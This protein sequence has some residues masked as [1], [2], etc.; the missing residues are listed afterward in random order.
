MCKKKVVIK[1]YTCKYFSYVVHPL[2]NGRISIHPFDIHR[3]PFNSGV[4]VVII[5]EKKENMTKL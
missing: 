1:G 5:L 3:K 2:D 4:K